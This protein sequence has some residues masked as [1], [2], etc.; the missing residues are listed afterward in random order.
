[1]KKNFKLPGRKEIFEKTIR[2]I[3]SRKRVNIFFYFLLLAL[4]FTANHFTRTTV[5]ST[6]VFILNDV[7]IPY[8]SITGIF[9]S[10]A[11]TCIIMIVVLFGTLGFITSLI[12]LTCQLCHICILVI[13]Y[14]A[15]TSTAGIFTDLFAIVAVFFLYL[16]NF[17]I[18]KYQKKLREQAVTDSLTGLPNRLACTELLKTL[19]KSNEKFI[20]AMI[21][22][23]N[24]K[25]INDTMGHNTGNEVLKEIATRWKYAAD[26]GLS[27]TRDFIT[28][29]GGD[30]F[31]LIIRDYKTDDDV[32]RSI[33]YYE[34]ILEKK[35]ILKNH[36]FFATASFGY[37]EYPF[38]SDDCDT[39][40]SYADMAMYN[41]KRANSSAHVLRFSPSLIKN[42]EHSIEIERKIRSAL[43]EKTLYFNLQ[44]QFDMSHKLRGFE[45]LA[46]MKDSEGNVIVPGEFIPIAE[47]VGLIDKIDSYV[48]KNATEFFGSLIEKTGL[49]AILSIN[50]SVRHLI[51]DDFIDE[52]RTVLKKSGVPPA[53]LEIEITESIMIDSEGPAIE[54]IN[55]LK[56]MGIRIAIDD[57]G[58]GYSSL[59]YLNRIPADVLKVDKSFIDKM[60]SSES[61]KQYVATIISIGHIMNFDVISEGVEDESQLNTLHEIGCDMIQGFIWGQPMSPEEA[62]K[63]VHQMMIT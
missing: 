49:D 40:F 59:S 11:N 17:Q 9:S 33:K 60:N 28:R 10:L 44:P 27:G 58:T 36:D 22:L 38:D 16:N 56:K 30:E 21:D 57:F 34:S 26:S 6:D 1:M 25:S 46:R 45:A 37:A 7:P 55:Q 32:L 50:C 54:N 31:T 4:Y 20:L 41:I 35:I 13:V 51:K 52:V 24:F 12:I 8:L 19:V 43:T 23:N 62:E 14:H 63:L 18:E 39:L 29:Q 15:Y 2:D 42:G 48:F 53:Q 5:H 3:I 61:S 47:S